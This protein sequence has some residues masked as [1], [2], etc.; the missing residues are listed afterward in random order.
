MPDLNKTEIVVVLDRSGSMHSIASD[1]VGGFL[2]FVREQEKQ[3]GEATLSLYQFDDKYDVVY[4]NKPL[5][6]I[7]ALDLTPR[8]K[9]AL[10]DA[11][12]KTIV[13]VGERLAA[14]DES[15]RP[16][17][18]VVLIITDGRENASREYS[19][20]NVRHL[21]QHQT[22]RYQWAFAYLGA[23][24]ST[25]ADAKS[26]GINREAVRGYQKN[27][28]GV[29]DLY[30]STSKSVTYYRVE[31]R[32]GTRNATLTID[33]GESTTDSGESTPS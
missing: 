30:D 13:S 3:P 15:R 29:R 25:F 16:G 4:E 31:K 27:R 20:G 17:A 7:Q 33:P 12:G 26:L 23:D 21:I 1:M 2:T 24:A 32:R 9:T 10:L 11:V 28:A 14:L 19:L 5:E 8:G 6:H 22:E 18:V